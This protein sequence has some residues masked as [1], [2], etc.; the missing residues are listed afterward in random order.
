MATRTLGS[1][2]ETSGTFTRQR[3]TLRRRCFSTRR[4]L[5][6]CWPF[7]AKDH[8]DVADSYTHA[9]IGVLYKN[10]ARYEEPLDPYGR[11]L[12][13]KRRAL[14]QEHPNVANAYN[15][16]GS[17]CLAQE[18]HKIAMGQHGQAQEIRIRAF[19]Q[20]HPDV[21]PCYT[22]I[23]VTCIRGRGKERRSA[24][25]ARTSTALAVCTARCLI[26]QLHLARKRPAEVL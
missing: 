9:R 12:E 11:A 10:Q 21:W 4:R 15:N 16:V 6:C 18:V 25:S 22:I 19:G 20:D 1:L 5:S 23:S 17:V 13:I 3:V 2:T 24:R 14:G 8:S 7:M 26:A